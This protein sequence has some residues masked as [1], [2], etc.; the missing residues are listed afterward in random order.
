MANTNKNPP[1]FMPHDLQM[2]RF[3]IT[4]PSCLTMGKACACGKNSLILKANLATTLS[5]A[6]YFVNA[7]IWGFYFT[8]RSQW[9]STCLHS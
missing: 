4:F 9:S 3:M 2:C 1:F 8:H 5:Q 7:P 6:P